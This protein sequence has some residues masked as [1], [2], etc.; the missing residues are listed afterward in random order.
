MKSD[1]DKKL[2]SA[3]TIHQNKNKGFLIGVATLIA[4][5][6]L[7]L[8]VGL[9]VS[10]TG[11]EETGV[12]VS[13]VTP[14]DQEAIINI[15]SVEE[16]EF[17]GISSVKYYVVEHSSSILSKQIGC[18]DA[19]DDYS[20]RAGGPH[21]EGKTEIGAKGS[22][23]K[24]YIVDLPIPNYEVQEYEGSAQSSITINPAAESKQSIC[25]MIAHTDENVF[26][27]ISLSLEP[28]YRIDGVT[29]ENEGRR[30]YISPNNISFS[31]TTLSF[32]LTEI[33]N[34]QIINARYYIEYGLAGQGGTLCSTNPSYEY[35][36]DLPIVNRTSAPGSRSYAFRDI[37]Y[38][39]SGITSQPSSVCIMV[40]Y[41]RFAGEG[42]EYGVYGPLRVPIF[43]TTTTTKQQ[44]KCANPDDPPQYGPISADF[45]CRENDT[46]TPIIGT[47]VEEQEDP[48]PIIT[49]PDP[50]P[51]QDSSPPPLNV[52]PNIPL[53]AI[54]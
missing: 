19:A 36:H 11:V 13:G 50:V 54:R 25:I 10:A 27:G 18:S 23:F 43:E 20:L 24:Q 1:K 32:N 6:G 30:P 47:V 14:T 12:F 34:T 46:R 53:D 49:V 48:V 28:V 37:A 35:L 17:S 44:T 5:L 39:I 26:Q 7:I 3:A 16:S 9:A 15:E 31:N 41:N 52:P 42:P 33:D 45:W 40:V 51:V 21:A 29:V 4:V 2:A 22:F 8:S 38:E